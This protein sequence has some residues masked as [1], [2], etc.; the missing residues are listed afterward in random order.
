MKNYLQTDQQMHQ[1]AQ[2][3]AKFNRSF[4]PALLDD[5]HTNLY[6]DRVGNKLYGRWVQLDGSRVIMALNIERGCY[7]LLNSSRKVLKSF[8]AYNQTIAQVENEMELFFPALGLKPDGFKADLHYTIPLYGW[9]EQPMQPIV[10]EDFLAWANVRSNANHACEALLGYLQME[11]EVRIWPH[12]FDTGVYLEANPHVG[13]GFGLA[14]ADNP[15]EEPYYYLAG[16][17]LNSQSFDYS[18]IPTLSQGEWR[19]TKGWNG[20]VLAQPLAAQQAIGDFIKET[21]SFYIHPST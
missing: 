3:I 20:A 6:F 14:M 18:T 2:T 17:G 1:M 15:N 13:I 9:L 21:L 4:V 12:H 11:G 8:V 10:K 5:S 19:L 16:Y 7:E